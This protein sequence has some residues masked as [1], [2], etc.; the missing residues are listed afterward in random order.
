M[1]TFTT[2]AIRFITATCLIVLALSTAAAQ[3]TLSLVAK[4]AMLARARTVKLAKGT[5][6]TL[7]LMQTIDS[8]EVEKDDEFQLMVYGNVLID[9]DIVIATNLFAKCIITE[10]EK[11]K[12]FGRPASVTLMAKSVQTVDGQMVPLRGMKITRKGKSKRV[13]T[14][15]GILGAIAGTA[16]GTPIAL[17]LLGTGFGEKGGHVQYGGGQDKMFSAKI[18]EDV[19]IK[20]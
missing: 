1:I 13:L 7:R 8:K 5:E 17:L 16:T 14:T 12:S 9:D 11:P 3:D 18:A 20:G 10:V 4:G 15:L 6:V 2:L 19:M